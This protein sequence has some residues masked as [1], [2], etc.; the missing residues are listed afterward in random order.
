MYCIIMFEVLCCSII[1]GLYGHSAVYHEPSKAIYVH[2]GY[3][4]TTDRA[5][6][7][8]NL[9][10]LDLGSMSNNNVSWTILPPDSNNR[11][12]FIITNFIIMFVKSLRLKSCCFCLV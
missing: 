5:L 11:V 3:E 1:I 4:Y 7:S 9:Y 8:S 6:V 2:G 12:S 10:V